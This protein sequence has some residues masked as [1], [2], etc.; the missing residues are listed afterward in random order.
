MYRDPKNTLVEWTKER[1]QPFDKL[2][3]ALTSAPVLA[4]PSRT[5]PFFLS[6]DASDDGIGAVLEQEQ[7]QEDGSTKRVVVAYA[8]KSLSRSQRKYCATNRELL[9]VVWAVENFRYY[10][11][12]RHFEI[13]TDHASLVWLSNFRNPEG[14]VA[15]WLQR[16]SPYD[17][18]IRHRPGKEHLN[19][20]G[21]S[22][23][24]CRPCKRPGCSDCKIIKVRGKPVAEL[25]DVNCDADEDD[26]GFVAIRNLYSA[27]GDILVE[28][29]DMGQESPVLKE[30]GNCVA[31]SATRQDV[32]ASNT[33][34][35][36]VP[37]LSKGETYCKGAVEPS[38]NTETEEVPVLSKGETYCKGAVEPSIKAYRKPVQKN[39]IG[40]AEKSDRKLR[41][42]DTPAQTKEPTPA[43]IDPLVTYCSD[44]LK[45]AQ[46]E[47]KDIVS[48]MKLL[49]EHPHRK[50]KGNEISHH[51]P[52]VKSLWTKWGEIR[53]RDGVL[54]REWL[55]RFGITRMRYMV[56]E[57]LRCGFFQG[58]HDNPLGAHQGINRTLLHLKHCYYWP[59]MIRDVTNWCAQCHVC[60]KTKW[61]PVNLRAPLHNKYLEHHGNG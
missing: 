20:D 10:L 16:L 9:A 33:E 30:E 54:F 47:D 59:N 4:Y 56:L 41:S 38:I 29:N 17:Y 44:D 58:L 11:L 37:V 3:T 14:M 23:Q 25:P 55:D 40:P 13:I 5:D 53:I 21:L 15:R 36:E 51:G 7:L 60:A 52:V 46:T 35:E 22:R 2:K 39:R 27:A 1:Q 31:S 45:K 18:T 34:T 26:A 32:I 6:T 24:R 12:G 61:L 8:S 19:A 49:K 48:I 50:P 28:T 42:K 57:T 43:S